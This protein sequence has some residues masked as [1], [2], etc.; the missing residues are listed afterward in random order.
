MSEF[1]EVKPKELKLNPFKTIGEDW[2]LIAAK[3]G[4]RVNAMTA[5]W[6]GLG[7]IWEKNAAFIFVRDSRFT[8]TLID[9]S[10]GFSLNVFDHKAN[11]KLLGYMGS[12]SGRN[13]D[14]IAKAGLNVLTDGETPY[15]SEAETVLICRKLSVHPIERSGFADS[16]IDGAYYGSQDYHKMYIGEI[17]RALVKE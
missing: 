13:E 8:K 11:A 7:V 10:N 3:S 15:F 9:S 17:V 14:K 12:A 1:I 6:G 2:L 5:S 16:S 4:E